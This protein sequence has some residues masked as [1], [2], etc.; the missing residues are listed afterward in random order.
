MID[1]V[2]N[3]SMINPLDYHTTVKLLRDFFTA[4]GYLECHPQSQLSIMAACE[5]PR[6]VRS[7]TFDGQLWPLPQTG[8][9]WLEYFL[10][11]NIDVEGVF[12][13][14]TSFRDEPDPIPGRHDKI[15]PMFEFEHTGNY[16]DLINTLS[17]LAVHLGLVDHI[18]AIPVVSY[19][20]LCNAY[21]VDILE[22]E[23]ELMIQRDYGDVVAIT[24]FPERTSPFWNMQESENKGLFQ[25]V[26]F[27]IKGIETFGAAARSSDPVQMRNSFHSISDGMYA[28]LLYNEFGEERVEQE[29]ED[30]LRL[31]MR[32]RV[33]AGIGLTRLIKALKS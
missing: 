3:Q 17:A 24:H 10:L 33:G 20:A 27:I 30:Y 31:P 12:C 22:A 18:S 1:K 16:Q 29:L 15:F 8:Q 21:G 28:K 25:K 13:V 26:D 4:R 9:M 23:H 2:Y 6:T 14:T 11:S 32:D 19:E 7:Y 5:D